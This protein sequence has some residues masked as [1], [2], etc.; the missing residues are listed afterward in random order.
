M[1]LKLN[2]KQIKTKCRIRAFATAITA[3]FVSVMT[4][5]CDVRTVH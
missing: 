4:Q 1:Q 2:L 3:N 5:A